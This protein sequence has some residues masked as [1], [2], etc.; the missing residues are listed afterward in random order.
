MIKS[1]SFFVEE[2]GGVKQ[3]G[4]MPPEGEKYKRK[5]KRTRG[6]HL[7]S[8]RAYTTGWSTTWYLVRLVRWLRDPVE[9]GDP[10]ATRCNISGDLEFHKIPKYLTEVRNSKQK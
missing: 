5:R 1:Q 8:L 7:F 4:E 2:D 6:F 10:T 3:T 9:K